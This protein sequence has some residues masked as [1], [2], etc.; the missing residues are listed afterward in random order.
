MVGLWAG[1][2]DEIPPHEY[3]KSR[4]SREWNADIGL[5]GRMGINLHD[6]QTTIKSR[7]TLSGF[8]VH[9]GKPVTISFLPADPDTGVVFHHGDEAGFGA[10]DPRAGFGGRRDRPL[11]GARRSGRP[12]CRHGRAC[13]GRAVRPRHRQCRRRN[14]RQRSA[15]PGRQRRAVRRSDRPGRHRDA[16]RQAPLYPRP[17]AGAHR[18]RRVLGRV[19]ALR[20]HALRGR[21]RLRKPG[22]RPPVLCRR[23]Q[24]RTFSAAISRAPAP[25][26]S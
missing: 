23:H 9:S 24:R 14:R 16:G 25:S 1:F 12:S 19:P 21:D 18:Q 6:Y 3:S 13:D 11:H 20:R 10:R 17:E 15:D 22:D 8:G 5:D 2:G 26:A 4:S 7:V